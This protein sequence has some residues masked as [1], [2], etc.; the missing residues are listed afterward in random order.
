MLQ[1]IKIIE[2]KLAFSLTSFCIYTCQIHGG[3]TED[4]IINSVKDAQKLAIR[5]QERCAEYAKEYLSEEVSEL[6]S[7]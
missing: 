7:I 4:D 6:T 3:T 1:H 5:N 2:L